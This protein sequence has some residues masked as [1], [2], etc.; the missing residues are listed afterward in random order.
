M[1][2]SAGLQYFIVTLTIFD[3]ANFSMRYFLHCLFLLGVL[4]SPAQV[5]NYA[6][7]RITTDDGKGLR[8]NV[9]Q[10]IFQD[11]HGF[12]WIGN[13]NGLQRF[14]GSKFVIFN[15]YATS[16]DQM[17]DVAISSILPADSGQMWIG[18]YSIKQF[19]IFD[20]AT[21]RYNKIPMVTSMPLPARSEYKLWQDGNKQTFINVFRYGK[22]LKYDSKKREFNENTP[23]NN[24]PAGWKTLL[25]AFH[26]SVKK[27]YWIICDSGL[28]V[29]DEASRQMWS[30]LNNPR[31]IPLLNNVEVQR[32]AS[33]FYIDRQRRYWIFNWPA[34]QQ[35]HCFDSTGMALR[36]TA[37]LSG[38]N[39]SYAEV[40]S[41]FETSTGSLF[42]YGMA[43]LYVQDK[44]QGRFT[45][46]RQQLSDNYGVGYEFI[47]HLYEDRDGVIWIAT[48]QGL[49]YTTAVNNAVNNIFLSNV[50]GKYNITDI[51]EL[52]GGQYWLSTWGYGVL[53]LTKEFKRYPSPLYHPA[54]SSDTKLWAAYKQVW[55]MC[56]QSRTGKVFLGC[57]LGQLMIYDTA[58]RKTEYLRPPEF[59]QATIRYITESKSGNLL[60]GTQS[61]RLISY[62]GKTYKVLID[63]GVGAI[64]YKILVDRDGWIWLGTQDKGI[65][66]INETT[67]KIE[68]HYTND[69]GKNK[70][71]NPSGR[72]I[73]QLTDDLIVAATGALTIINK[74]T[75]V[76]STISI[77]E[78]LPSNSIQRMRLDADGLL[79]LITDN[80]LCRYD[81][82]R[83]SFTTY[84]KNDGILVADITKSADYLCSDKFV[85]FAGVNSLLFFHPKAFK[86]NRPT[87]DVTI[88]DFF[89]GDSYMLM[90]SLQSLPEVILNSDQN[91]FTITFSC[92]DFKNRNK[93]KY[94]YQMQG[95]NKDWLPT[96]DLS[97]IYS[98]LAPGHYIFRVKAI[99]VDGIESKNVTALK[100]YVRPPFWRTAWFMSTLLTI[101][102]LIIYGMHRLRI[103]RILAVERIRNRVARDLHDDMGSTLSTINILSAMAKSKLNSDV[104]KTSEYINKIS[105]NS[106]RMMEAMDD[107]VWAIKPS[108]DNMQK[109]VCRMREFATN[110]FE[111]KDIEIDFK[112]QPEVDDVHIDME[113]RRDF[114]LV[115]KEAVNNA[116]KYSKC[117]RADVNVIID[118]KKLVLQVKDNG[119]GF[120][121]MKADSGNGLGNMQ[122]RASAMKGT[123]QIHSM[124]NNGTTVTLSVPIN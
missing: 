57:Q 7:N 61:G 75:G 113:A 80:G 3:I 95:M 72:D 100:I 81:Y 2:F 88:T 66:A 112:A 121:V 37:G 71:F 46:Y 43:N 64:I 22:I 96:D 124:E 120:N 30:K 110:V 19:G 67:G 115:F 74:R 55:A 102:S 34:G 77:R 119:I 92:L 17:P 58:T 117:S 107:I 41:F 118:H 20:P 82:K 6:F 83:N 32:A 10:S 42:V 123:L 47:N 35:F 50:P 52:H 12:I 105:D 65:Y 16:P 27:Q 60:F 11:A 98:G 89:R 26:D 49:Y 14:D 13:S 108:N 63:L 15:P 5:F 101:I 94:L 54:D 21:F 48:D 28:C 38:V 4:R 109:V 90:D 40:N 39:T 70:L 1:W 23:L 91:N 76:V 59:N 114:F 86:I 87:P 9:V 85:M 84:G 53:T 69:P 111:A 79:W 56:Q 97:I 106:Q 99:N 31:N 122:K 73:E 18:A 104:V 24:I 8:S 62:D 45:F 44:G 68:Q 36:D 93:Y 103:K 29:Y 116:A 33:Q 78:G 25:N 51:L